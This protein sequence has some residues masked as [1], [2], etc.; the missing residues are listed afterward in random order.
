MTNHDQQDPPGEDEEYG[1][2]G[3]LLPRAEA[4]AAWKA[5]AEALAADIA[6]DEWKLQAKRQAPRNRLI[7]AE[8]AKLRQW[9]PTGWKH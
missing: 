4:E 9:K 2:S 6:A 8:L 7:Q 5:E 1:P 3:E